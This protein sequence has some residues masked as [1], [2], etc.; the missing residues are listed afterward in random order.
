LT[1]PRPRSFVRTREAAFGLTDQALVSAANFGATVILA[2]ALS[3]TEFGSF[4][5]VYAG[6]LLAA[7]FQSAL[8]TQ[9]HNVLGATLTGEA[10]RRYTTGVAIG[11]VV[12]TFCAAASIGLIVLAGA[13]GGSDRPL[14]VAV[15]P[16]AV[17]VQ[18]QEFTR[19][20]LYTERRTAAILLNDAISYGGRVAALAALADGGRLTGPSALYAMAVTAAIATAIGTT[21]LLKS[22]ALPADVSAMRENWIF[23]KWLVGGELGYWLSTQIYLFLTAA[24]LATSQVALIRAAQVL[25]GPLQVIAFY[26][27]SVLPSRFARAITTHGSP[28]IESDVR[29]VH[30]LIVPLV[31]AYS[32]PVTLLAGPLLRL[33]YGDTYA[34]GSLIV[35]LVAISSSVWTLVPIASSALRAVRATRYIFVGYVW[36]SVIS[37]CL[38]WAL[39]KFLAAPG[40]V[41]GMIVSAL[42]VYSYCLLAYR[43]EQKGKPSLSVG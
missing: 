30:Q 13:I 8:I 9:P 21:Q 7:S 6:L 20:V 1:T 38:G 27:N 35:L 41:T 25:L 36:A 24:I 43:R 16:A 11:Q 28:A 14:L 26:L 19:R 4:T 39:V 34:G 37:V 18:F 15:I 42:I 5:L 32:V 17:A 12:F 3:P 2:R 22:L 29:A 31:I 40:A 23:G 33:L 10:Y